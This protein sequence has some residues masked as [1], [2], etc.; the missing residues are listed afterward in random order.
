MADTPT[1]ETVERDPVLEQESGFVHLHDHSEYSSLDGG[2]KVS[3]MV[4][5]L[6]SLGM[7]SMALTDH[8]VMQGIPVFYNTLKKAG[9]KPILGCLPAGHL[10]ETPEGVKPIEDIK[11]GD[12][13]F[14][15]TRSEE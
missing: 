8:G 4:A 14:T 11:V 1:T 9:M 3:D 5:K 13:V 6:E 12:R 10:I 7:K 2:S 15:H